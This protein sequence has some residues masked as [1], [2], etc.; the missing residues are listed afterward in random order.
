MDGPGHLDRTAA[1]LRSLELAQGTMHNLY[2]CDEQPPFVH[3]ELLRQWIAAASR[4]GEWRALEKEISGVL[5]NLTGM[6]MEG[7]G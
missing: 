7:G 1:A 6:R 4:S 3:L 5:N 2:L